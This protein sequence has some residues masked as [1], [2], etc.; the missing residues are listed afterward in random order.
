M[1]QNAPIIKFW[2]PLF[3]SFVDTRIFKETCQNLNN[4]NNVNNVHNLVM[5]LLVAMCFALA[6]LACS[7]CLALPALSSICNRGREFRCWPR[8]ETMLLL[9]LSRVREG[10][11]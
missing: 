6:W 4:V 11:V 5:L 2:G 1:M 3:V 7:L 9:L 10:T 8:R